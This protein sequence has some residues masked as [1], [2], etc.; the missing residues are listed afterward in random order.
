MLKKKRFQEKKFSN[1]FVE[2]FLGFSA[3]QMS[4]IWETTLSENAVWAMFRTL[5]SGDTGAYGSI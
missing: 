2:I 1:F 5:L 3:H 4:E